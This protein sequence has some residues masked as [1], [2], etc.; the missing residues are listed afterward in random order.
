MATEFTID[1]I[2]FSR[3]SQTDLTYKQHCQQY[4]R[5]QQR[6]QLTALTL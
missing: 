4:N 6:V 1:L 5:Q 2:S 3:I